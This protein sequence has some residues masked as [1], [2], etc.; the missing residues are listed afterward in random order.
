MVGGILVRLEGKTGLEAMANGRV[1]DKGQ[2]VASAESP[3]QP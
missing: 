2:H 1:Q 3:R